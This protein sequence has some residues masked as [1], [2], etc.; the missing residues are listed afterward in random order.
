MIKLSLFGSLQY[1]HYYGCFL[2]LMVDLPQKTLKPPCWVPIWPWKTGTNTGTGRKPASI[3]PDSTHCQYFANQIVDQATPTVHKYVQKMSNRTGLAN[4]ITLEWEVCKAFRHPGGLPIIGRPMTINFVETKR[5]SK[6]SKSW[7][8]AASRFKTSSGTG[9]THTHHPQKS[10]KM[11][12]NHASGG[13]AT[14]PE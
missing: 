4:C 13:H 10:Q 14:R 8:A 5:K 7:A 3:W 11:K 1:I 2:K 6:K 12:S 9:H